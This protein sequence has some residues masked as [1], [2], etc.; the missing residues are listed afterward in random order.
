MILDRSVLRHAMPLSCLLATI[1]ACGGGQKKSAYVAMP[2][3]AARS[4]VAGSPGASPP[5][6]AAVDTGYGGSYGDIAREAPTEDRPGLGTS[7]GEAVTAPISFAPF[8]R[9]SSA[10][11]AEVALHYNDAQGVQAHAAY[12]HTSAQPM[13]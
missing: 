3:S 6:H 11:W 12:L 5:S 10:P 1:A 8:A 13:E 7:W 4:Y 9:A 2:S